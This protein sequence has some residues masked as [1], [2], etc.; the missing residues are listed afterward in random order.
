MSLQKP[1]ESQ[2]IS[3]KKL[4]ESWD[5]N[6]YPKKNFPKVEMFLFGM[7]VEFVTGFLAQPSPPGQIFFVKNSL[8]DFLVLVHT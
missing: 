3:Q 8:I 1:S 7:S 5:V 2:R 4:P 6:G